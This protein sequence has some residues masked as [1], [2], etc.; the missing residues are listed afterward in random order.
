MRNS[1][2]AMHGQLVRLHKGETPK[3]TVISQ[4]EDLEIDHT[5]PGQELPT[6]LYRYIVCSQ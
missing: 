3:D 1:C 5:F 4:M 2:L 6:P